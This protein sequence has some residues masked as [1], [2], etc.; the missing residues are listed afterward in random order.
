MADAIRDEL[1]G[2]GIMVMDRPDGGTAWRIRLDVR[3][4]A[5]AQ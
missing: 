2:K 5:P 1:E 3:E 4:T